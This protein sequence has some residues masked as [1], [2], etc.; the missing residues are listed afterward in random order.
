MKRGMKDSSDPHHICGD[1]NEETHEQNYEDVLCDLKAVPRK[2]KSSSANKIKNG[3]PP[4][5]Q[6]IPSKI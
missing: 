4:K 6:N 2:S 1:I 5:K 3:R